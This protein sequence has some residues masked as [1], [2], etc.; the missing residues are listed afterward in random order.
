MKAAIFSTLCL[1]AIC[2]PARAQ[3][4]PQI[5]KPGNGVTAPKLLKEV[6]AEYPPEAMKAGIAGIVKMEC[7]VQTD[8]TPSDIR[9]VAP[10]DSTVDAAAIQAL[11]G[12]KFSPGQKD[13]QAVPVLVQV[14]MSFTTVRGPR[15]G[16]TDVFRSGPGITLPKLVHET[17]PSYSATARNAGV[18]GIVVLDCVILTD[19]TVG[20]VR[21]SKPLDSDL[22]AEA[23]RTVRQWKF[24][25]GEKEGQAVPVQVSVELTFTLR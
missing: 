18:Q 10:L 8:G 1:L 13:G 4:D 19:G 24:T 6:K 16:S 23:I 3:G 2:S 25:P 9:V 5:Y 22:D 20:D 12:W 17:K 21:V 14:E 11:K 7:V 15:L